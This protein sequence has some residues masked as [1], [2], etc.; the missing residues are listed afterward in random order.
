MILIKIY[1]RDYIRNHDNSS[2]ILLFN[3]IY[4]Y[5]K[6]SNYYY[7]AIINIKFHLNR[8]LEIRKDFIKTIISLEI[9][10]LIINSLYFLSHFKLN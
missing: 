2:I 3:L 6:K 9:V 5:Y 8:V 1:S 10:K 7:L 4:Y